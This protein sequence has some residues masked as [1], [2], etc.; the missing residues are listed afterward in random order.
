VA[1]E[2]AEHALEVAPID[3]QQPVQA[4]GAGGADEAFGDRVRFRRPHGRLDDLDVF[5]C[6]DRVEVAAP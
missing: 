6:E 2:D 1:G 4:L 3:D 5:A